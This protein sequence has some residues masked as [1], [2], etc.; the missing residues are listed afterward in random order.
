MTKAE[1]R[2]RSEGALSSGGRSGSLALRS[3]VSQSDI[4]VP[5]LDLEAVFSCY[6]PW[7]KQ[8]RWIK[9]LSLSRITITDSENFLKK[10]ENNEWFMKNT[11][12]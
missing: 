8:T 12:F 6:R 4:S 2:R 3:S 11:S 7:R 10:S 1:E 5:A 9:T